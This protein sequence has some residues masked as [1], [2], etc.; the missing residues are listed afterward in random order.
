M[1]IL[2]NELNVYKKFDIKT[3][4]NELIENKTIDNQMITLKK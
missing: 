2:N 4:N 1:K 3:S